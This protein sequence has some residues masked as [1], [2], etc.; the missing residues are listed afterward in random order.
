MGR[1]EEDGKVSLRR[2]LWR[3]L[4]PLETPKEG[5][6]LTNK[7]VCFIVIFGVSMAV[8]GTEEVVTDRFGWF[9]YRAELMLGG[10]FSIE[11]LLRLW[12]IGERPEYA[13]FSGRIRYLFTPT[14]LKRIGAVLATRSQELSVAVL[15]A[16]ML[17]LLSASLLYL[18][19]RDIQPEAFGSIPRAMWWGVATLTTVGYGD[20]YPITALGRFFAAITAL[21]GIGVVAMPAGILAAAFS[22]AFRNSPAERHD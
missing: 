7:L 17:L 3:E 9:I 5:L 4:D 14:A 21:A 13:G 1:I 12:T 16:G 10:L 6:T 8:I 2:R 15:A 18:V 20:V 11:Y 19:E 22:E